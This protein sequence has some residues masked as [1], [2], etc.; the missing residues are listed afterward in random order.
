VSADRF[1]QARD[2]ADLAAF[3]RDAKTDLAAQALVKRQELLC[4]AL[5]NSLDVAFSEMRSDA[6]GTDKG[7]WHRGNLDDPAVVE[8]V[9]RRFGPSDGFDLEAVVYVTFTPL[10]HQR[11]IA[12]GEDHGEWDSAAMRVRVG[13]NGT[14][15]FR[16]GVYR[17][18]L[19]P[20]GILPFVNAQGF[21]LFLERLIEHG[22]A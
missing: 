12:E 14:R 18:G 17:Y 22:D 1:R 16:H 11:W 2:R 13:R 6:F 3:E 5:A 21:E 9:Y 7:R 10:D 15:G 19:Q 8:F 4:L 20:V